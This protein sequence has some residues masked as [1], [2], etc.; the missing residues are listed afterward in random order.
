MLDCADFDDAIGV[1]GWPVEAHVAGDV[2]FRWQR[3]ENP[4]G[5][6]QLPFRMI[7]PQSGDQ[8]LR[9]RPL[10]VDDPRGPVHRPGH[11]ALLRDG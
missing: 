10:R 1:N 6:N 8:P 11:R 2:E 7:V 3:G 9:R 4:R 5:F